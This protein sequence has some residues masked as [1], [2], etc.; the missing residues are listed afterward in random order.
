MRPVAQKARKLSALDEHRVWVFNS[1]GWSKAIKLQD[2]SHQKDFSDAPIKL[3]LDKRKAERLAR[4]KL[5]AESR[6]TKK[7]RRKKVK[8]R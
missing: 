3:W 6:K 1:G 5:I 8:A 7:I 4:L 2:D